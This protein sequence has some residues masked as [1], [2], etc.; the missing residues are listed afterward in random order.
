MVKFLSKNLNDWNELANKELKKNSVEG[1]Q[2]H[3]WQSEEGINIKTLYTKEDLEGL[4]HL[5]TMPGF[6]PYVRGPKATMYSGC[7]L[8]L[9]LQHT[10]VMT[11]IIQ[12][13]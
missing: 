11:V 3:S 1:R 2:A 10:E 6:P 9:T 4:E 7:Q 12:E 13:L 8:P 5:N